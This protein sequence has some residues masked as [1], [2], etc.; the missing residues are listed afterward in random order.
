MKERSPVPERGATIM[1]TSTMSTPEFDSELHRT[2]VA[3]LD[4]VA[5]RLNLDPNIHERLRYPRRA[6]VVSVPVLMD[7]GRTE[8]FIGYRVHHS[9]ALGPTKGGLRYDAGVNLGLKGFVA[10][11]Q[12]DYVEPAIKRFTSGFQFRIVS[13]VENLGRYVHHHNVY[14]P[15]LEIFVSTDRIGIAAQGYSFLLQDARGC[16]ISQRPNGS[17]VTVSEGMNAI[18]VASHCQL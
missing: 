15:Q 16:G 9:T 1:T 17:I 12:S 3:Q 18:V 4:T 2:A 5:T 13:R 8:V 11:S 10:F 6:L 7:S 14:T